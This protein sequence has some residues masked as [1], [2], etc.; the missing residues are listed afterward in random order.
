M[1]PCSIPIAP[2]TTSPLVID[3]VVIVGT[4]VVLV[5]PVV[6]PEAY[7]GVL[8]LS[9]EISVSVIALAG[10]AVVVNVTIT[11]DVVCNGPTF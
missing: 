11:L 7:V 4:V 10:D 5:N 2:N 9:D 8:P 3:E 1:L 6:P